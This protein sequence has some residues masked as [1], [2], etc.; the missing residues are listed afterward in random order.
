VPFTGNFLLIFF[1]PLVAISPVENGETES[2]VKIRRVMIHESPE[3]WQPLV[4][5]TAL[6]SQ[7]FSNKHKFAFRDLTTSI[8][9]M[10]ARANQKILAVFMH[11][12]KDCPSLQAG[13]N[14]NDA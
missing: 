7:L 6:F 11:F 2:T 10:S 5:A 12:R 14:S 4:Q 13:T 1:L 3:N 9:H 8:S